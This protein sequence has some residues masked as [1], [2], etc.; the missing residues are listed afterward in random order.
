MTFDQLLCELTAKISLEL[1]RLLHFDDLQ[2]QGPPG[3]DVLSRSTHL[4]VIHVYDKEKIEQ[5]SGLSPL[6][7]PGINPI[8]C[9]II[10]CKHNVT[11]AI[12]FNPS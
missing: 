2:D 11:K 4:E 12:A 9:K 6:P 1:S 7:S 3:S 10:E 5:L 8:G